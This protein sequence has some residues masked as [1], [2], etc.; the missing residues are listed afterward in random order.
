MNPYKFCF[1]ICTNQLLLLKEAVHYLQHIKLPDGY[2][3]ELLTVTKADSM[4]SGYQ[5][6]M[7]QSDAKYKIYMHQ[8]VYVLNVNLLQNLLDIFHAD[9]RVGLIGM[10]GY[11]KVSTDGIMWHEKRSGGLYQRNPLQPYPDLQSY[12]YSIKQDGFTYAALIDG[13]FMATSCDFF[14]E[15]QDLSGWDFYDAYQS[16]NVLERGYRIAVPVQRHPWCLHDDNQFPNLLNYD[17]D[18][19]KFQQRYS[20]ALGKYY[21]EITRE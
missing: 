16:I 4:T 2:E 3:V 15:T 6:A 13:F 9:N 12:Q 18:R 1:I 11:E 7:L 8:D 19:Q 17:R 21:W 5:N 10:V 14:W 20:Y